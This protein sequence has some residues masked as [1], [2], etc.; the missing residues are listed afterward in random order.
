[1]EPYVHPSY[2]TAIHNIGC[3]SYEPWCRLLA[4]MKN[5]LIYH[6]TKGSQHSTHRSL[7]QNLAHMA[8]T[9]S[10]Q[11]PFLDCRTQSRHCLCS[12]SPRERE[13][14]LQGAT[15]VQVTPNLLGHQ[16]RSGAWKIQ[17]ETFR[18]V[19]LADS[20]PRALSWLGCIHRLTGPIS[21]EVRVPK[22]P[23]L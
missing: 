6:S 21:S 16:F 22:P 8:P 9:G 2:G 11:V 23:L 5:A 12:W 13:G 20:G 4:T 3:S 1:M 15:G 10:K 18:A 17:P 19:G 7:T 14:R